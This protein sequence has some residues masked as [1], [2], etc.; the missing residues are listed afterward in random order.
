MLVKIGKDPCGN[1]THSVNGPFLWLVGPQFFNEMA[2][3]LLL[4][5]ILELTCAQAPMHMVQ[6]LLIRL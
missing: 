3:I 6:G 1:L 2:Q 4:M 5:K